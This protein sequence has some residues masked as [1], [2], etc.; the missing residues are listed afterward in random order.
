M[1]IKWLRNALKNLDAEAEYIAQDDP[2]AARVVVQRVAQTVSLL[3]DNP[4]LGHP[5]RLP[6]THELVIPKTRYIVPYRVRP[7]LQ[8][9]EI[10]R[11]FHASRK[12]P[13]RW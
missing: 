4:S 11:V 9:I 6:G 1:Q 2:Q 5:G 12:L 7:R 3:S 13:K 8:R 10:L